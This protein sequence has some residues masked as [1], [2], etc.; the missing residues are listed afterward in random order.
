M[1][2]GHH[3]T[4]IGLHFG[5][6]DKGS[7]VSYD[8]LHGSS[9]RTTAVKQR[10]DSVGRLGKGKTRQDRGS[11]ARMVAGGGRRK[12]GQADAVVSPSSRQGGSASSGTVIPLSSTTVAGSEAGAAAAL[13]PLNVVTRV[14][15]EA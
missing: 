6:I 5:R 1:A 7:W 15:G 12:A 13:G 4:Q 2:L 8:S 11:A 3:G 9:S 10:D 14:G